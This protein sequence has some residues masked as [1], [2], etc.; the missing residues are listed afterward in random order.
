[1]LVL[2]WVEFPSWFQICDT[3]EGNES[4]V[5]NFNSYFLT[6][7]SHITPKC[8]ILKQ[9]PLQ[10]DIWLQHWHAKNNI[11]QRNLNTVFA[12]ISKAIWPTSDLFLLIMSHILLNYKKIDIFVKFRTRHLHTPD[13]WTILKEQYFNISMDTCGFIRVW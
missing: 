3:I 13:T 1:M 8:F 7:L 11:K 12:N 5:D 10:L 9:T 4:L 2:I 6:P